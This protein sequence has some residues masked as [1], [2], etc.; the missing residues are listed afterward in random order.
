MRAD[1]HLH[2]TCSDGTL[3]P[4]ELVARASAN[5]VTAMAL[6]DHDTLAGIEVAAAECARRGMELVPAVELN[7]DIPNG[8]AHILG[9]FLDPS[10]RWFEAFL[11]DRRVARQ[12][13]GRAMVEQ[14][15]AMGLPLTYEQVLPFARGGVVARPHVARAMVQAGLVADEQEAFDRYLS[16][17]RPAYV[18]RDSLSPQA[19]IAAIRR[20]GG[21]PVLAHPAWFP[22]EH[23]IPALVDSGLQG[24][25]AYYSEHTPEQTARFVALARDHG[26]VPTVG[27]DFHGPTSKKPYEPGSVD[28]P[29]DVLDQLR[30]R[31]PAEVRA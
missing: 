7:T 8:E 14:L 12:R 21:V 4:A 3:P 26:L 11:A 1:L 16:V 5:G 2:S 23:L 27:S 18:I 9:Y 17:G 20:A 19:A 28:G 25:E 6:S 31:R 24:I 30:A 10:L 29:A 22:L 13:R 15:A